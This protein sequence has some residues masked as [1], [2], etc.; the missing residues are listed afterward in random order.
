MNLEISD[1]WIAIEGRKLFA[2]GWKPL[3]QSSDRN[4][5]I[6]L[7]HD[8]IGCVELWRDFPAKLAIATGRAVVAYD[9]LGFGRSDACDEPLA[10]T[11]VFAMRR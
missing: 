6:L 7:F 9:R 5:T 1:S 4:E 11:F 2:R 10:R 3:D 8:S